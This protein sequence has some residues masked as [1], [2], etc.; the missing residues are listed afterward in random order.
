M[1][2]QGGFS[3]SNLKRFQMVKLHQNIDT[4][5]LHLYPSH[6]VTGKDIE[7]YNALIDTLLSTKFQANHQKTKIKASHNISII[8]KVRIFK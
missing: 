2:Y 4:L 6:L 5:K 1:V 7:G 8:S 3:G